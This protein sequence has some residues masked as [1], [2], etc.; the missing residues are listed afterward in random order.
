M[1]NEGKKKDPVCD[2]WVDPESAAAT[3][4]YEGETYY[5]CAEGCRKA[6]EEDPERYLSGD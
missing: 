1:S 5:F 6:F 4:E 2:M 3:A